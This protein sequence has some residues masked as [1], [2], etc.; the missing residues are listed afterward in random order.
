MNKMIVL[1]FL[2][3]LF[4]TMSFFLQHIVSAE[5]QLQRLTEQ[6]E[7]IVAALLV[8]EDPATQ[9]ALLTAPKNQEE[10]VQLFI[11]KARAVETRN[12]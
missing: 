11:A 7:D 2:F 4:L 3:V 9:D 10:I 1:L 5:K 12:I 6:E 8:Q